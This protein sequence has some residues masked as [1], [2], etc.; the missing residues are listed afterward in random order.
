MSW[1]GSS[2]A[3]PHLSFLQEVQQKNENNSIT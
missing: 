3:D 1:A 2:F